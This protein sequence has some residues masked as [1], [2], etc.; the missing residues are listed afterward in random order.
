MPRKWH[1]FKKMTFTKIKT[2]LGNTMGIALEFLFPADESVRAIENT[3]SDELLRTLPASEALDEISTLFAY[4]D[5]R[6][7][8]LVWEI[9]YYRN[10]KI[11]D[12][13]GALLAEK[14]KAEINPQQ[15]PHSASR[16][17]SHLA[18]AEQFFLAPIPLTSRRLRE[19]GYNHTE[20]LAKSI[21]KN[22]PENFTLATDILKKIRHTPKQSSIENREERFT[23]IVGAFEV[24]KPELVRNQNILIIDD[25]VTT[26]ATVNEA[27]RVFLSAGAKSMRTFAVAH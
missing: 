25:V 27:K 18:P 1:K 7:K 8:N 9:K 26:G 13:V 3:S 10:Q 6:V 20:L 16:S 15:K 5:E 14:I 21:L 4:S 22:L 17:D 23:N 12:S 19:R 24:S 11:T 2:V